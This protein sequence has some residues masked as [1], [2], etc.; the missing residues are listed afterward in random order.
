MSN[1]VI[2]S[3]GGL[4]FIATTWATIAF[5][6]ARVV[7]MEGEQSVEERNEVDSLPRPSET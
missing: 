2:F 3:I 1:V 5:L 7:R 6:L 4:L